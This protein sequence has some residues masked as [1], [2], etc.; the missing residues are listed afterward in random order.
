[1]E[2]QPMIEAMMEVAR[3]QERNKLI[4]EEQEHE[5]YR[6]EVGVV[7]LNI[8]KLATVVRAVEYQ[9]CTAKECD[10][11]MMSDSC[12]VW[13]CSTCRGCGNVGLF[14]VV[15]PNKFGGVNYEMRKCS[16]FVRGDETAVILRGIPKVFNVY[17]VTRCYGGPQEGG[18]WWGRHEC[19]A[20]V[21]AEQMT[22]DIGADAA[23]LAQRLQLDAHF[24]KL[25]SGD[26]YSVLGGTDIAVR[27][28]TVPAMTE[29]LSSG[30]YS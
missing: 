7:L 20:T 27:L 19:I 4:E 1:M 24:G 9:R 21:V 12:D 15:V 11:G 3:V 6:S 22:S 30:G 17:S 8:G 16:T 25:R 28:E 18:W 14:E 10:R 23:M 29:K 13:A 26:V 5:M 2:N